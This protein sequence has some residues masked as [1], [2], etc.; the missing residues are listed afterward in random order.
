[1][2]PLAYT[3]Y[4][5]RDIQEDSRGVGG[6]GDLAE[7][8]K[9]KRAVVVV[10][11]VVLFRYSFY[12]LLKSASAWVTPKEYMNLSGQSKGVILLLLLIIKYLPRLPLRLRLRRPPKIKVKVFI[13]KLNAVPCLE[14]VV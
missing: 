3:T 4:I 1:M 12:F 14:A 8:K 6:G 7:V 10:V 5:L 2:G 13:Q 11:V 9:S